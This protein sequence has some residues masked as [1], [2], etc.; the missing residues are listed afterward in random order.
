MSSEETKWINTQIKVYKNAIK[1]AKKLNNK[2]KLEE[3]E[4]ELK[5]LK[6]A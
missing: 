6:K 5:K 3:Y 4:K 1:I 2:E